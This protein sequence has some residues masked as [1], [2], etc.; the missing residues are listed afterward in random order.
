MNSPPNSR[1]R[2]V[3]VFWVAAMGAISYIDRVNLSIAGP[4]IAEEF[5]LDNTQLGVVFGAFAIG[6]AISQVGGGWLA[7]RLGPRRTLT[8]GAV[9]WA[10]LTS[11]TGLVPAGLVRAVLVL[12]SIRFLLGVGEAVMY[13]SSNRW[14]ANW[15]P[16]GERGLANGII[17]AG[18]GAGAALTPPLIATIIVHF[19]W[20]ESF[21]LCAF[22][23]LIG[24]AIW[25]WLARDRPQEHPWISRQEVSE[26]EAGIEL[27]DVA[28]G[29]K[30][31]WR[32][33]LTSRDVWALTLSYF[34]YGYT[35]YIF[36]TWFFIYLTKV[37]GV[38]LRAGTL[39]SMLPFIAMSASSAL[40]G[41]ICDVVS[42]RFGR[43]WGRCRVAALGLG[44][45]SL[46]VAFGATVHSAAAASLILAGGAGAVY[47]SQSSYWALS[48]DLGGRSSGTLSGLVNMGAQIG[49]AVTAVLTP[50]IAA[51]LRWEASFFVAAALC[52]LGGA[53]WLVVDPNH[54]LVPKP[55][56]AEMGPASP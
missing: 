49:S 39:Y 23:G 28:E 1:M 44:G 46:F 20:R 18:V 45:A 10:L 25:F 8:L 2:W 42:R 13:P 17:F 30:L 5:H 22:L 4:S 50:M 33:L 19:G 21:H 40:G 43:R 35:A 56:D 37:R 41:W 26:I 54:S 52:A 16:T 55:R 51:R 48:A 36:F 9:W 11:S 47:I 34:T 31:P 15:I 12:W 38:N 24:G 53:A 7:D 3:L 32:V 6:Y 27:G 14:L 29:P